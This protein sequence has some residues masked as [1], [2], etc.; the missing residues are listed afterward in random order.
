MSLYTAVMRPG[1]ADGM[2]TSVDPDQTAFWSNST[3]FTYLFQY[4]EHLQ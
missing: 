4:G 1:D 3:L 2:V